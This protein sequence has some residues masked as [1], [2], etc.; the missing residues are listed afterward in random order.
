MRVVFGVSRVLELTPQ[1]A[2]S[3]LVDWAGHAR[4]VPMTRVEVDPADPDRFT[5]WSG[6]GP[7]ALEDRMRAEEQRFD[8]SNGYCRVS[9]LGPVLVGTAEFAV[10]P[11]MRDGTAVVEWREDV[12]VPALP[13][14]LVPV[15][16]AASSALF[17]WSLRRMERRAR[18]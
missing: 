18:R 6:V 15:V 1:Q 7:L 9:K 10:S 17:G 16:A 12:E 13:R 4:W 2:W 3:E 5:A 8:G 14:V 11:A